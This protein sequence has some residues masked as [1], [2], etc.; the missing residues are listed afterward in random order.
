MTV[1][2]PGVVK[3]QLEC[4]CS[5]PASDAVGRRR[6]RLGA[7]AAPETPGG[8]SDNPGAGVPARTGVPSPGDSRRRSES[9]PVTP[10]CQWQSESVNRAR[11]DWARL[12]ARP[13]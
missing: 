1:L 7:A 6:L 11:A 3:V 13:A 4:L 2:G 8:L 10:F 9:P 5:D 12:P